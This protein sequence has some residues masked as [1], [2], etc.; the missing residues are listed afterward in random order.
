MAIST[1]LVHM[2][3]NGYAIS[4]AVNKV[5]SAKVFIIGA[6]MPAIAGLFSPFLW[7]GESKAAMAVPASVIATTL[8]P[9]AYLAFILLMNS[10]SALGGELP[11]K[12]GMINI[13]MIIS[14]GIASFASIWAL[15]GKGVPGQIGMAGL[16]ILAVIG[17]MGFIKN[18]KAT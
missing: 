8:L 12:R 5:G 13:L 4:E 1:M 2:M 16:A 17:I 18:N 6:A 11:K 7:S 3:M 14:A 9:I 10:K 15:S